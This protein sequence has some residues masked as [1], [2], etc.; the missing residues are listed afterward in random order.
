ML[1][2]VCLVKGVSSPFSQLFNILVL[3]VSKAGSLKSALIL[4]C[5]AALKVGFWRQPLVPGKILDHPFY[6][7]LSR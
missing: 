3:C 6:N 4:P 5:L 7:K 1:L 2:N